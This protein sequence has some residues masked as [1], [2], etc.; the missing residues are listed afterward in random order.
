MVSESNRNLFHCSGGQESN[1]KI[2]AGF[3]FFWTLGRKS[4]P[5]PS[6]WHLPAVLGIPWPVSYVFTCS[7]PSMP[8][9]LFS[10]SYKDTVVGFRD[11]LNPGW[12][13]S[14]YYFIFTS[15]KTLFPYKS[16]HSA[17]PGKYLLGAIIQLTMHLFWNC[18]PEYFMFYD[19]WIL[20]IS[21]PMI[22]C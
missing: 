8:P 3:R 10:V 7:S 18:I 17:V 19:K 21:F 13:L 20:K 12:S 15:A 6:S 16:L 2:L 14:D 11:H 22:C 4:V 9:C 5:C 1:I